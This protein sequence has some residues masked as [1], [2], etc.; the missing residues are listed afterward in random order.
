MGSPLDRELAA[1]LEQRA[2]L[3]LR[4][5]ARLARPSGVDLG[6]N[7]VL[8]LARH[9][10]VIAGARAALE[11]FGAGGRA[12]RLLGG[13]SP[14][15]ER[16]EEAVAAWTGAEAALLFPSGYQANLGLVGALAGRGDALFSDERNPASLIDAARLS[17][18]HVF[19]HAH[20]DL[21]ELERQLGRA[22]PARRRLVLTEG[23]FSMDGDAAP[24]AELDE[25]C[26]R[27]DAWLVVD[28]AH[29]AGLLGPA[30]AGAWAALGARAESRLAARVVT[31]GKALGV[32]G[33]LVVGSRA[34]RE[35]L[36]NH[37]RTF[38]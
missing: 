19:V 2:A 27:H 21:A 24:L 18:A 6:S 30:G 28:E 32:A 15:H 4:R 9:P 37:A 10:R 35:Q 8:G 7:D 14:L 34:L 12:A 20:L 36:V 3:G 13:G 31:G 11:E 23:V 16:V 22:R 1:E 26:R 29:S 25:L 38:L 17:R 5:D 33:A